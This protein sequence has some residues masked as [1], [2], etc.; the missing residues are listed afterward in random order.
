MANPF[1]MS[2]TFHKVGHVTNTSLWRV[3]PTP[4]GLALLTTVGRRTGKR[5]HRAIRA[6]RDGDRVYAVAF[7]GDDCAWVKNVRAQ[8]NVK[9]KLGATTYDAVA[10]VVGDAERHRAA[11]A[12]VAAAGWFDYVDYVN[13]VWSLPTRAKML[14]AYEEWFNSGT[15]VVFELRSRE[16]GAGGNGAAR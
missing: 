7:F 10:S 8:P 16:G 4:R 15:P 12:Y 2:K 13:F 5:R 9:L 6:V 14:R 3:S 1:A 11:E